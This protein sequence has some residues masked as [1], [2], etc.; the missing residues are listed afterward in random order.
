MNS[1]E[2]VLWA[3]SLED[4]GPITILAHNTFSEYNAMKA[5]FHTEQTS[6]FIIT[7]SFMGQKWPHPMVSVYHVNT[8]LC[9]AGGIT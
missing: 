7:C 3:N 4:P 6:W 9:K 2:R 5:R 1:M 8:Y